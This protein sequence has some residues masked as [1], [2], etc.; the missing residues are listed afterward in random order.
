[1]FDLIV[2][3]RRALRYHLFQQPAQLRDV[4]LPLAEIIDVLPD[5]LVAIDSESSKE[6]PTG[7]PDAQVLVKDKQRG[8]DCVDYALRLDMAVPQQAIEIGK[9]ACKGPSG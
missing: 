5:C 6:G 7:G 1:M 4:P 3:N 8:W 9:G 2:Q